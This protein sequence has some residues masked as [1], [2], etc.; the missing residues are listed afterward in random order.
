MVFLR[1]KKCDLMLSASNSRI[2]FTSKEEE[3]NGSVHTSS[4]TLRWLSL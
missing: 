3:D 2:Y 1:F 4:S